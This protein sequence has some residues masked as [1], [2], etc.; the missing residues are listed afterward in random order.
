MPEF[1]WPSRASGDECCTSVCSVVCTVPSGPVPSVSVI[2]LSAAASGKGSKISVCTMRSG[3][4]ISRYS[5]YQTS[6]EPS[7]L[8]DT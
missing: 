7:A 3:A 5:P 2:V 8:R 6:S 4:S 1:T